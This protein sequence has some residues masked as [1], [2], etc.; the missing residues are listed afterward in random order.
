M[1]LQ[2]FGRFFFK[3]HLPAG[4]LQLLLSFFAQEHEVIR[5][6]SGLGDVQ[7]PCFDQF[8]QT[9][10]D[11]AQACVPEMPALDLGSGQYLR[12]PTGPEDLHVPVSQFRHGMAPE[13]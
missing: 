4:S 9:F 1:V 3:F 5:T 7:E 6:N 11:V 13:V 2:V 12:N 8:L 10:L